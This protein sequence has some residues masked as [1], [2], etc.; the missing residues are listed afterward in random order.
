M[1][2]TPVFAGH[3]LCVSPSYY[4]VLNQP[5]SVSNHQAPAVTSVRWSHLACIN[6]LSR[7][8]STGINIKSP[9]SSTHGSLVTP[10]VYRPVNMLSSISYQTP[11]N[12]QLTTPHSRQLNTTGREQDASG[13]EGWPP[14]H[15]LLDRLAV[16]VF[17]Y[18]LHDT[19]DVC[20]VFG[21]RR[22]SWRWRHRETP[23][24][25]TSRH[26]HSILMPFCTISTDLEYDK[27]IAYS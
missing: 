5:V 18:F 19:P 27:R 20:D 16:F 15:L 1:L 4:D 17:I 14:L 25:S 22:I 6:R 26:V 21:V 8:H 23:L 10:C 13:Q 11:I 12:F 9:G 24:C 3:T 7:C 2:L